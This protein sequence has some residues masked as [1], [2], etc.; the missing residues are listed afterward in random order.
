[1][2]VLALALLLAG[3]APLSVLAVSSSFPVSERADHSLARRGGVCA[4]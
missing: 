3:T 2:T 4:I 1:M